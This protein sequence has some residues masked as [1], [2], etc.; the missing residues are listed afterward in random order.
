M[1]VVQDLRAVGR[2]DLAAVGGKA[3][4]L[5]ELLN[6]GL[7]VPS[8]FVLTTEAYAEF[9]AA[10]SEVAAAVRELGL[11]GASTKDVRAA[12]VS[13][14]VPD[15]IR[16]ALA[17]AYAGLGSGA[18]AV[19]SSA[20]A[21]DLAEA[22]FAGQQDTLLNVRGLEP[23]LDAVRACWASLWTARAVDY[24]A[25]R[26]IAADDV[27]LAVVVQTMV[28]ADASGVM[29]TANPSTGRRDETVLS[30]AWG[31]GESVVGGV[32]PSG[33]FDAVRAAGV[34]AIFPPGTVITEAAEALLAALNAAQGF[35]QKAPSA[36]TQG[37]AT[38]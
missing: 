3:A 21:E 35:A 10:S 32:I 4:N 17:Q 1:D 18:V 27:S 5:G 25:R 29:F 19:R 11:D 22:S 33:D 6:A 16:T 26:G 28:E 37:T 23:L 7:P 31:L 20:T 15:A 14:P 24:R 2:A 12:F 38:P 30:A 34:T 13:A 9:V 36:Y 8:G